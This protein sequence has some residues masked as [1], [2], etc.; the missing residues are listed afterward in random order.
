V[1]IDDWVA[2]YLKSTPSNQPVIDQRRYRFVT[3]TML[4]FHDDFSQVAEADLPALTQELRRIRS[5]SPESLKSRIALAK[6]A[7]RQGRKADAVSLAQEVL[8]LRP[9]MPEPYAI[10][11]STFIEE[12]NWQGAADAFV[13]LLSLAGDNYPDLNY[14][15]ISS[16]FEKAGYS[17]RAWYYRPSAPRKPPAPATPSSEQSAAGVNP[18]QDAVEFN[19]RGIEAVEAG[20]QDLAEE[21]FLTALKLNPG[22]FAAWSN[23]CALYL[24]KKDTAKAEEACKRA[25]EANADSADAHFNLAL[26]YYR[27]KSLA[28]SEK[29][30]LLAKKLGRTKEADQLLLAIRKKK[31]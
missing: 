13:R 23:L 18:A 24:D 28:A 31:S 2:V 9:A 27:K 1:Y 10:L 5:E 6:L 11:A 20:R 12:K 15:Y 19:D 14:G 7:L 3:P 17:W 16:V 30:A 21:S 22:F 4:Q 8:R 25:V 26:V 29:E